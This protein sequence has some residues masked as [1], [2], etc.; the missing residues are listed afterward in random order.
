MINRQS[1]AVDQARYREVGELAEIHRV[2][3]AEPVPRA[4]ADLLAAEESLSLPAEALPADPAMAVLTGALGAQLSTDNRVWRGDPVPGLR[5][6]ERL[7]LAHAL[8]LEPAGRAPC[9]QAIRVVELAVLW[10]L[11]WQQMRRSDAEGNP[12]PKEEVSDEETS[13]A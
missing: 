2:A 7:L 10:R 5:G 12:T 3:E 4:R 8:A 9:L 1:N 13:P 6:L 11:R